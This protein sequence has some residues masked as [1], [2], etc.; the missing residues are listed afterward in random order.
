M[1]RNLLRKPVELSMCEG[2]QLLPDFWH[3][4]A[5][6]AL[7]NEGVPT[8][9]VTCLFSRDQE[10][11]ADLKTCHFSSWRQAV[12]LSLPGSELS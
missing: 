8:D 9:K 1:L 3:A 4:V 11:T 5:S 6:C 12:Q 7:E 10:H 2:F